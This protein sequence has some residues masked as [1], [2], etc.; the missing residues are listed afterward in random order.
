MMSR[1]FLLHTICNKR[2]KLVEGELPSDTARQGAAMNV[3][4]LSSPP[5]PSTP[6]FF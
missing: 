2:K 5:C 4:V 3:A 6:A 1:V